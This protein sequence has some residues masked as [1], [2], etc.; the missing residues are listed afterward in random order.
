MR[1]DIKSILGEPASRRTLIGRVIVS[2]QARE[3]IITTIEQALR[4]Y[5]VVMAEKEEFLRGQKNRA[6]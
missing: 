5:D 4:A 1:Y 6:P 2:T 3:G